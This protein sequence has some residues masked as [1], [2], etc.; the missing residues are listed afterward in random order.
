MCRPLGKEFSAPQPPSPPCGK[1]FAEGWPSCP[2]CGKE[3][4]SLCPDH[5]PHR[6]EFFGRCA[7]EPPLGEEFSSPAGPSFPSRK[8]LALEWAGRFPLA[9]LSATPSRPDLPACSFRLR[10]EISQQPCM[11]TPQ[12]WSAAEAAEGNLDN[13]RDLKGNPLCL[14][15]ASV[16]D[17]SSNGFTTE[18]TEEH[19]DSEADFS[20]VFSS[21]PASL[22]EALRAGL[23][24]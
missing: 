9:E 22:S 24:V 17:P 2:L 18:D 3:F 1:E 15:V 21:P 16:V 8:L 20:A 6:K 23:A 7:L 10:R 12:L 19:R 14:S 5:P 11:E 13:R 4:S